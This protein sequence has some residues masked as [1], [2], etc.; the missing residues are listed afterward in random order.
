MRRNTIRENFSIEIQV[1]YL[2]A[3]ISMIAFGTYLTSHYF[4]VNFPTGLITSSACD[5]NDFINCDISTLSP[6]SNIMGIPIAI[7]GALLGSFT[8]L[9]YIF[10]SED[11]ERINYK[12]L[13]LNCI[14]CA[15]L[16][17]YSLIFLKSICPFCFLYYVASYITFWLQYKFQK[18][19][20]K[21]GYSLKVLWFYFLSSTIVLGFTWNASANKIK[22]ST[23]LK[24]D[25]INQYKAIKKIGSPDKDS[26]YRL[27]SATKKF[28]DAPI[29]VTKFSDFQCP[30]CKHFSNILHKAANKYKGRINIQYMFYPLDHNCNYKVKKPLHI[31]ACK[32]AYLASCLPK[33]FKQVEK[34]IF[35]NQEHLT[36]KWLINYAKKHNILDCYN[37]KRTKDKIKNIIKL[38]EKY[39]VNSTPTFILN[40]AKINGSIP[41][42]M[43]FTLIDY[44][45]SKNNK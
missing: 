30:S 15:L 4:S 32:A 39:N 16:F 29:R 33:K 8:L 18:K 34:D 37:S 17:I 27:A 35:D 25:L 7:L 6:L 3:V 5:I 43:L 2:I 20:Y 19:S 42:N 12:L 1:L 10:D 13:L 36:K 11:M 31:L 21:K 28:S 41:A 40:G 45:L 44:I 22:I 14:L 9:S 38:S 23:K 24:E 26:D